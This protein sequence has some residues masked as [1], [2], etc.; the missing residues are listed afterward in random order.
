M[1]SIIYNFILFKCSLFS[2]SHEPFAIVIFLHIDIDMEPK[3]TTLIL[4]SYN[5]V[6]I[7]AI[8]LGENGVSG[9]LG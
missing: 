3:T 5:S 6:N 8:S 1:N 7:N 4:L 2:N 9:P